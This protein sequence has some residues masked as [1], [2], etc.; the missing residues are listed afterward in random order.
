MKNENLILKF[1]AITLTLVL[2]YV[3]VSSFKSTNSVQS[4]DEIT[5]QRINVVESDG[6]L[7]MVIIHLEPQKSIPI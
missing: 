7:K 2:G 3:L 4:F 5:V 6:K 1:Y